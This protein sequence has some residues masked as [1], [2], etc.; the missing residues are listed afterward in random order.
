MKA[1]ALAPNDCEACGTEL[2]PKTSACPS[3]GALTKYGAEKQRRRWGNA[4][5]M[6]C[7]V[8]FLALSL[9]YMAQTVF[10]IKMVGALA[11]FGFLMFV[12]G[13]F[14]YLLGGPPK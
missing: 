11:I 6:G 5:G 14:K 4:S 2:S 12:V 8:V 1:T 13:L 3:C 10:Q 7:L 9:S